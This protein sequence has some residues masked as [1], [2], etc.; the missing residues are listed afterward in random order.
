MTTSLDANKDAVRRFLLNALAGGDLFA[1]D[2][3]LADNVRSE[4]ALI[5]QQPGSDKDGI[6]EAIRL[7]HVG[8]PDLSIRVD[9]SSSFAWLAA[10]L[11]GFAAW[12]T[13]CTFSPSPSSCRISG[14]S[15]AKHAGR[16]A[17]G[18]LVHA[19]ERD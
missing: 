17:T 13:A 11:P 12:P 10:A 18:G 2:A 8:F 19:A 1:A 15:V 6:T 16:I 14:R 9:R 5:Y 4:N 7:L 3:L